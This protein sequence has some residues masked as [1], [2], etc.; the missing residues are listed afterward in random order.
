MFT[1]KCK[2]PSEYFD[3]CPNLCDPQTCASIG[4]RQ[5]CT[6][7]AVGIPN[8]RCITGHYRNNDNV[9]VPEEECSK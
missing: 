9:C 6:A 5:D 3:C 1:E 8:C 7:P 2:G 4:K